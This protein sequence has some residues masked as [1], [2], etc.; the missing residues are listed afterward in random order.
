MNASKEDGFALMD[1]LVALL[2][3]SLGLTSLLLLQQHTA[4]LSEDTLRRSEALRILVDLL[5][6][7][8][9]S[10]PAEVAD[11]GRV[12]QIDVQL[13]MRGAERV[14]GYSL[15]RRSLTISWEGDDQNQLST[16]ISNIERTR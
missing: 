1:T 16:S 6:A 12:Y 10:A 9:D 8:D 11:E 4:R 14:P 5:P 3:L 2:V 7:L 13:E 15:V